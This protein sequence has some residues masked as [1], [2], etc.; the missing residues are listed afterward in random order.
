MEHKRTV[1]SLAFVLLSLG[2]LFAQ[3]IPIASGGIVTVTNSSVAQ[4]VNETFINLELSVTQTQL[5]V[6]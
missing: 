2:G 4:G 3:E 1:T 5:L 6:I